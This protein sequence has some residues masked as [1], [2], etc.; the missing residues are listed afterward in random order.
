MWI[1]KDFINKIHHETTRK[2]VGGVGFIYFPKCQMLQENVDLYDYLNQ[3]HH[4]TTRKSPGGVG[5][6]IF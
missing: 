1:S 5:C 4:E 6:G 3:I 2:S